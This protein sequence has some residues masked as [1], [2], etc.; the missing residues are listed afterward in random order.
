MNKDLEAALS[1]R[2]RQLMDILYAKGSATAAE[3]RAALSDPPTDAAVRATLRSLV[4]KGHL[5]Y[6]QDGPRYV[7]RPTMP[8]GRARR[9]ALER[10]L[11]TFFGGSVEDA[12]G[13]LLE[14][15]RSNLSR[16]ERERLR[17][18]IDAA[19]KEGR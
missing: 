19:E 12:L 9:R 16:E 11:T 7:Y 8:A 14:L 1:R 17:A 3:A 15:R 18:M 5:R 6:E 2:E 13:A 10:V 4:A